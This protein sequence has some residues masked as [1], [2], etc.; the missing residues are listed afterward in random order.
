MKINKLMPQG[1]NQYIVYLDVFFVINFCLDYILLRITRS[2][3]KDN[4]K[5]YR[6]FIGGLT[7]ALYSII[8]I[9]TPLIRTSLLLFLLNIFAAGAMALISFGYVNIKKAVK[10]TAMLY[11]ITFVTGGV[12]NALYYSTG[13]G[14]WIRQRSIPLMRFVLVTFLTYIM[15]SFIWRYIFRWKRDEK[16]LYPV[17]IFHKGKE[18]KCMALHDTGNSLIEPITGKIVHM[19]EYEILKELLE[20]DETVGERFCMIPFHSVG[21]DHGVLYGIRMEKI[22]IQDAGLRNVGDEKNISSDENKN[23]IVLE[24]PVVAIYKGK[25]SEIGEYTMILNKDAFGNQ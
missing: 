8:V 11:I 6:I 24:Q 7:G 19:A 15:I 5:T 10:Q 17:S 3:I 20:G 12:M 23:E 1:N 13:F 4:H 16:N 2:V 22:V 9:T 18:V 14:K 21:K 25:L